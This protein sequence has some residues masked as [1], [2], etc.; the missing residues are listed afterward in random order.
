MLS[1]YRGAPIDNVISDTLSFSTMPGVGPGYD[2]CA[3]CA[4]DSLCRLSLYS[5]ADVACYAYYVSSPAN[6]CDPR[7]VG[8]GFRQGAGKGDHEMIISNSN[9]AQWTKSST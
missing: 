5:V 4:K 2:C 8:A 1:Q 6:V 7:Q 9:C 3:A